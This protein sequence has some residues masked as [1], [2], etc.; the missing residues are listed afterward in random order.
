MP[1][2]SVLSLAGSVLCEAELNLGDRLSE[3]AERAAAVL[4]AP[5][6]KL[7]A[8]SGLPLRR[9][10]TLRANGLRRDCSVTAVSISLPKIFASLY[11]HAFAAVKSDGSVVTWGRQESGGSISGVASQ[12][13]SGVSS[14][15]G[16]ESAFAALKDDGSV[17]TWG[18]SHRGGDSGPVQAQLASGVD[19]VSA[20]SCAFAAV[21]V[22]GTLVT[23]GGAENNNVPA[24]LGSVLEI[25]GNKRAFAAVTVDGSVATWGYA[26]YGGDSSAVHCLISRDVRCVVA[27]QSAFAALKGDGSVITWGHV[28]TGGDSSRV[29]AQISDGVKCVVGNQGAFAA[30]K[31]DGSVVTWG[32]VTVGGDSSKVRDQLCSEVL[33]VTASGCAFAATKQGGEVVTWGRAQSGG[34]CSAVR[35]QLARGVQL[36][37]ATKHAFAALKE[38][39]YVV[40][41]G[42]PSFGGRCPGMK[43]CIHKLRDFKPPEDAYT[44]DECRCC[45]KDGS[46]FYGC[47]ECNFDLCANCYANRI[48]GGIASIIGNQCAFS[49]VKKDGSVFA[50]GDAFGGGSLARD[51][52]TEG[53]DL[54]ESGRETGP[55]PEKKRRRWE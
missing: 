31:H 48:D 52:F 43:A 8:C 24:A 4:G 36:V 11:G 53:L 27:T 7:V 14:V 23:W 15:V 16:T 46:V 3:L 41:W 13:A 42:D 39:G 19:H 22:D 34:D 1:R 6:C 28:V 40:T 47:R 18:C 37:A 2:I 55:V 50:W 38:G 25:V 21:K 44:C 12:V 54:P 35:G 20:S 33:S 30:L 32:E 9:A 45:S 17:V 26:A 10:A 49:A 29:R 51:L 5:S